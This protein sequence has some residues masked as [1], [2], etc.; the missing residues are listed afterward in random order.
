[1][2]LV[3]S[4]VCFDRIEHKYTL[5][6]VE[7]SGITTLLHN[8]LFPTMYAGIS[9]EVLDNAC[10]RGTFIHEQ[11]EIADQLH[12][13]SVCVE[14]LNYINLTANLEH[15]ATE[16]LVSDLK[17]YASCIDKVYRVSSTEFILGDIK[18]TSKLNKDYVSWQLSIY[19]HFF[20]KQNPGAKVVRL[21][22][23]WLRGDTAELID[24]PRVDSEQVEALLNAELEGAQYVI[25]FNLP[26]EFSS[27]EMEIAGWYETL[28]KTEKK[29]K[30]LEA[31]LKEAM[32]VNN[33]TKFE[34]AKLLITRKADYTRKSLDSKALKE[35]HPD[36]YK[37]YEKETLC[38]GGI[39]IKVK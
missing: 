14:A 24:V 29:I 27:M 17:H 28:H 34:S 32:D 5:N 13:T 26:T 15:E 30:E 22:G 4:P 39:T 23:I 10:K 9:Q 36:I 16:Y 31:K 11:C 38:K 2:E 35:A 21:V 20:E 7:L 33:V 12:T 25:P 19:A 3:K 37:Q 1:M 8:Q 18:T 6:G